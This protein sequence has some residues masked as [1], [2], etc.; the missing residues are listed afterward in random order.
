MKKINL[1]WIIRDHLD[2]LVDFPQTK[3][4][5]SDMVV[6]FALPVAIAG[7]AAYFN[8]SLK[9]DVLNG[10]MAAFAIFAGLLLN[11]LVLVFSFTQ[12]NTSHPAGPTDIYIRIRRQVLRQMHA[13]ISFSIVIALAVVVVALVSLW[14]LKHNEGTTPG[15]TGWVATFLIA[16]LTS[17]FVLTLMMVL[18]RMHILITNEFDRPQ[19][20]SNE[21]VDLSA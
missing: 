10:L 12:T 2:T 11:L 20:K 15:S 3:I 4:S 17:N 1:W 6:F 13:N 5:R 7:A 14:D 16:L 18:K 19:K 8:F 21:R 9:T